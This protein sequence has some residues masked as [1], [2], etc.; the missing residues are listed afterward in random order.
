MVFQNF[1]LQSTIYRIKYTFKVCSRLKLMIYFFSQIRLFFK[2]HLNLIKK[3]TQKLLRMFKRK[4]M[5]YKKLKITLRSILFFFLNVWILINFRLK[6][7]C[8]IHNYFEF[9]R[10]QLL[11]LN[12]S[13]KWSVIS[14]RSFSLVLPYNFRNL[15]I[16]KQIFKI[17]FIW[18]F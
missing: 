14:E 6:E 17:V 16:D 2:V 11:I 9:F 3:S 4:R 1:E 10:G 15:F 13:S 5:F 18:Y 7:C 8:S 12:Y